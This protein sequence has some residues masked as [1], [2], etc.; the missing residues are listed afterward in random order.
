MPD[1]EQV[2]S[3]LGT[4]TAYGYAK[5]RGYSGTEE[6]FAEAAA[7]IGQGAAVAAAAAASASSDAEAAASSAETA[8]TKAAAAAGSAASATEAKDAAEQAA[9]DAAAASAAATAAQNAA[10][11]AQSNAEAAEAGADAAMGAAQTAEASAE[12]AATAAQGSAAAAAASVALVEAY[13][14]TSLYN[15]KTAEAYAAGTRGGV[16][17]PSTDAAYHN[18]AK[19]YAEVKAQEAVSAAEAAQ[20]AAQA[21]VASIPAD[22][23]ALSGAVDYML[24]DGDAV[25]GAFYTK[26]GIFLNHDPVDMAAAN[27]YRTYRYPVQGGRRYH[28]PVGTPGEVSATA[29]LGAAWVSDIDDSAYSFNPALVVGTLLADADEVFTAP[30]DAKYLFYTI[31]TASDPRSM[32][33]TPVE[34]SAAALPASDTTL[35]EA[36]GYADAKT[37]GD[38]LVNIDAMDRVVDW[39]EGEDIVMHASDWGTTW[40]NGTVN[41]SG[42]NETNNNRAR[43][44]GD[45]VFPEWV[46][47]ATVNIAEGYNFRCVVCTYTDD[48][49]TGA[50]T[51]ARVTH[52]GSSAQ[53]TPYTIPKQYIGQT[54]IVFRISIGT[55]AG[56]A[57]KADELVTFSLRH[58]FDIDGMRAD[59]DANTEITTAL[60]AGYRPTPD[61]Y[62]AQITANIPTIRQ[63]IQTAGMN[64]FTFFFVTD[65]HW[66]LNSRNSPALMERIGKTLNIDTVLHGGDV[67]QDSGVTSNPTYGTETI[68]WFSRVGRMMT[69]LGNH[70]FFPGDG[71]TLTANQAAGLLQRQAAWDMRDYA[72]GYYYADI[73]GTYTRVIVLNTGTKGTALSAAQ[74]AFL[75]RALQTPAGWHVIV[76]QHI[77]WESGSVTGFATAVGAILD[78]NNADASATCKVEAVFVG[79]NH[80]D[81]NDMTP[82]GIPVIETTCDRRSSETQKG[83]TDEGAFDAVTIDYANHTIYMVRTG[84]GE[85]RTIT[86][87][88]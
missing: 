5:S 56:L 82:L 78:A 47:E 59:I 64:G 80:G 43:T 9:I 44:V 62:E 70:D 4:V 87:S 86:Y 57:A 66:N 37:V 45:F 60:N 58:R 74:E 35:T 25:S 39:F 49:E 69:A 27:A 8:T 12:A 48:P 31:P 51:Y 52:S 30:A 50:R 42:N 67:F 46:G 23:S 14:D 65:S 71:A 3:N 28:A 7:A 24:A 32:A 72:D 73:P 76:M 61:Y 34:V 53:T 16:D 33:I 11:A 29:T 26:F 68:R 19:Y 54:G 10:A 83:T 18:N 79:H 20:A 77:W 84:R 41:Q 17:V 36:G 6:E 81:F 13:R 2:V 38:K 55:E 1:I 21:A 85:S 63:N 22:Y 15:A 88:Y 40:Q 75:R